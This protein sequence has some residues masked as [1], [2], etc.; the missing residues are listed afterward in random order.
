MEA[1]RITWSLGYTL[2]L[3]NFQSM[4]VDCSIADSAEEFE[5]VNDLSD[6]VYKKVEREL[7]EKIK[8]AKREIA[9]L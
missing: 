1:T 8:E 9:E 6:R 3:G 7:V 2:N 4:R 5:N